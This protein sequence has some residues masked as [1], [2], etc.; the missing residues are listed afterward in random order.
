MWYSISRPV[1]DEIIRLE[2]DSALRA[3]PSWR[4]D[5]TLSFRFDRDRYTCAKAY[6]LLRRLLSTHFG[7]TGDLEFGYGP[8]GKPFLKSYPDIHFNISHCPKAVFCAVSDSP[9]GVDVEEIQYD[10]NVAREVFSESELESIRSAESPEIRFTELW[11]MKE[12][13]LKLQG[14]GL[15]DDLKGLLDHSDPQV[16]LSVEKD[17]DMSVVLCVATYHQTY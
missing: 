2:L 4:R 5:R 1:T 12:A 13:Y 15:S 11:T 9:I 6:L 8:Y 7:I 3:I 14:T 10:E 16:E 17:F